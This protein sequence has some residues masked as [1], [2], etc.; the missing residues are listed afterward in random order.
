MALAAVISLIFALLGLDDSLEVQLSDQHVVKLQ[1][2][3]EV[4]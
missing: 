1:F 3:F 4:L 2:P